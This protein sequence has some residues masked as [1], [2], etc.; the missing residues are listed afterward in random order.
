MVLKKLELRIV[1]HGITPVRESCLFMRNSNHS[2][3]QRAPGNVLDEWAST[4]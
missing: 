3:K 2:E 1:S 4:S